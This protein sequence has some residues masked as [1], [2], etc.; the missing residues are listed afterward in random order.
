MIDINGKLKGLA[1]RYSNFSSRQ[2]TFDGIECSCLEGP[3]QA[4]KFSD[5]EIQK[6]VC[7]LSGREAKT[8]GQ[9]MNAEWQS[10]QILWWLGKEYPRGS[11]EY[12]QLL[13]RLF[14]TAFSGRE[15]KEELLASGSNFLTHNIGCKDQTKTVLT[16]CEFCF[17][18]MLTR[19]E[20][21]Q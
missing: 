14:L 11:T 19:E 8:R 21:R 16:E 13:R 2:F 18:I 3:I 20:L 10:T 1:G 15:S 5:P 7:K 12:W 17:L 6:Q 4:F 9:E